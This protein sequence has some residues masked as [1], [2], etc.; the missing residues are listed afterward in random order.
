MKQEPYFSYQLI[1][2]LPPKRH[3]IVQVK[4]IIIIFIWILQ[5]QFFFRYLDLL[6]FLKN[7][8][9]VFFTLKI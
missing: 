4:I 2:E 6:L 7:G 9:L 1:Q 8:D 3:S 5:I